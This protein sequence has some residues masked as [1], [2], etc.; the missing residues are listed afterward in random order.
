MIVIAKSSGGILKVVNRLKLRLNHFI[1]V[2]KSIVTNSQKEKK[3]ILG[4][5]FAMRWIW[6]YATGHFVFIVCYLCYCWGEE[7]E[8]ANEEWQK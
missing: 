4:S 2:K 7:E 8:G 1:K 5:N 6:E 3:K